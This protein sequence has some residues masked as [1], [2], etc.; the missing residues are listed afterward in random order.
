MAVSPRR[1]AG[2]ALGYG[3]FGLC[4]GSSG[5]PFQFLVNAVSYSSF[6]PALICTR[7]SPA[8]FL[9]QSGWLVSAAPF[10]LR[11]LF[12]NGNAIGAFARS[13]GLQSYH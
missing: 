1:Q 9:D 6:A 7:Q 5:L 4:Y 2:G 13:K 10:E 11:P 8:T 3:V 12:Q